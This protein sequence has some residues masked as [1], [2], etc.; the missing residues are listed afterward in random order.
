MEEDEEDPYQ[1]GREAAGVCIFLQS[2]R[3]VGVALWCGYMGGYPL[4]GTSPS[5]VP[6]PDVAVTDGAD[7]T[8][9]GRQEV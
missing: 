8:A 1:G 5:G 6:E 9:A 2:R 4:H 3:S 7:P